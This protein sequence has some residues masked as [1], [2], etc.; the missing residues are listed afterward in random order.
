MNMETI[1]D[2]NPT[3]AEIDGIVSIPKELYMKL[4][5]D[6]KYRDLAWLYF[7]RNDKTKMKY[8][9]SLVKGYGLVNSFYRTIYHP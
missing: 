4:S 9:I 6:T 7:L 8:Y 5:D 3:R 2:H 1:F